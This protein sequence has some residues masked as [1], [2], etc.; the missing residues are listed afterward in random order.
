MSAPAKKGHTSPPSATN[1]KMTEVNRAKAERLK[2]ML[3][4]KYNKQ[5]QE[6]EELSRRR[7]E[8]EEQMKTMN[9]NEVQ[10]KKYRCVHSAATSNAFEFY[11]LITHLPCCVLQ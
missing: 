4:T 3:A 6:T 10:K 1:V 5:R 11:N 7:A 2:E 8:L 9:L